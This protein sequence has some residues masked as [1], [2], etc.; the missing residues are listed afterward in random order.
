MK[1]RILVIGWGGL[2]LSVVVIAVGAMALH[3]DTAILSGGAGFV[4]STILKG[5][6]DAL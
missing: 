3:S 5:I 1:T 6:G 2:L 4:G